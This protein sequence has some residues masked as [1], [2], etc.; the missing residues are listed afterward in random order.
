MPKRLSR[1]IIQLLKLTKQE[2][3]D[4]ES[5]LEETHM[6][7]TKKTFDFAYLESEVLRPGEAEVQGL[8]TEPNMRP[9][10]GYEYHPE[11][12]EPV[13]ADDK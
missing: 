11:A 4:I 10:A 2:V 6:S 9:D 3:S 1:D 7:S 13:K 8:P 5:Q 12:Q